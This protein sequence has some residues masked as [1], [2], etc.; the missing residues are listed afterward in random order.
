MKKTIVTIVSIL[1][2]IGALYWFAQGQ[3]WSE[4]WYAI[5][6]AHLG[7]LAAAVLLQ[8]IAMYIRAMRWRSFLGAPYV[9]TNQLFLISN[10]GF[11]ANGVLPARMGELIRPFLV[12]RN[13]NHSFSAAL[14]TI[15]VERVFDL[16]AILMILAFVL[17]LFPFPEDAAWIQQAANIGIVMFLV[18]LSGI[19]LIAYAPQFSLTLATVISKPFPPALGESLTKAVVAFGLGTSTFKRPL[20]FVYCLAQTFLL[21]IVIAFSELVVLWAFG[22]TEVGFLGALFLMAGLCFAVMA[23]Q[24]P[25][26]IGVYQLATKTILVYTFG[27]DEDLSAAVAIVMWFTQVPPI[28]IAGFVCLVVMGISFQE[29]SHVSHDKPDETPAEAAPDSAR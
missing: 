5:Q 20:S 9:N 1:L 11:M 22:I 29:I 27:I 16:L 4:V 3:N 28:I 7:W 24:L 26:Y 18:L 23:P 8:F 2:G 19:C 12:G 15:V 13:T 14:A 6:H 21:W 17:A 25:G 10:I